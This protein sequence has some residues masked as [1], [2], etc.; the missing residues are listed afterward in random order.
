[1]R[2]ICAE[3]FLLAIFPS[4][5]SLAVVVGVVAWFLRLQIDRQFKMRA[6]PFDVPV[7]IFL[8][9][10]AISVF[11][12]PASNFALIYNYCGLVGVFGLTYLLVGQ[13]IRTVEQIKL[14]IKSL[15]AAALIVVLVGYFQYVFG[16]DVAE[17]TWADG[18]AFPELR[19]RVFSTMENPNV[20]A[21]YLDV[22]ICLALGFLARFGG[23]TQKFLI[24]GAILM[25]TA[26]LAMTYSHVAFLTLSIIF[27][28]YGFVHDW[29]I[30]TFT[31]AVS[32][33]LLYNDVISM[34]RILAIFEV[35]NENLRSGIWVSTIS[36]IADHPF[37]GI[38]WGA[39]QF[40][41]PQYTYYSADSATIFH[42]H[43]LYL[44]VAAEIG[45][46]GALAYFWY[47]FGTM[48]MALEII[49]KPAL[50]DDSESEFKKRWIEKLAQIFIASEFLQKL[51]QT[52]S[53][54][55]VRMADLSN[56]IMDWF[57]PAEKEK[58][59]PKKSE[60]ELVHHEEMKW[61]K[62][63][64]S[65]DKKSDDDKIDIQKFAEDDEEKVSPDK[66]FVEG[67]RLG[68]GLA[69][70]SIALNGLFENLLF[71]VPSSILMWQLGALAAAI[72]LL[73]E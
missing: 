15:G 41:Y 29:R 58:P 7:T 18:E 70:L 68:I 37:I 25:L 30:L 12:S 5:A 66:N 61:R 51:A 36:M 27:V 38:G 28:I 53:L 42:A 73:D 71:D 59:A 43:N 10:G 11:T 56:R 54:L 39:F 17:M 23:K 32:G 16:I 72:N 3:A 22:M 55:M 9:L 19:K 62:D 64:K 35:P 48:F 60:P 8:L 52:K 49:R 65:A 24:L 63:K 57:T 21:G 46:A 1:M 44:N 33:I 50:P 69:F 4:A 20:L 26:C 34:E 40:V 67:A 13:N 45:I 6:L 2:A 47:F 14:F 31:A